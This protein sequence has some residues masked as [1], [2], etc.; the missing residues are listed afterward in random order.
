MSPFV[1]ICTVGTLVN[2]GAVPLPQ[3]LSLV[4]ALPYT[5]LGMVAL[6]LSASISSSGRPVPV[7][8]FPMDT[9]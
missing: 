1:Q 2:S 8:S 4:F 3:Y 6:C 7:T 9:Q 5:A